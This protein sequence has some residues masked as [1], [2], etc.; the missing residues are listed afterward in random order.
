MVVKRL[1]DGRAAK[2][3]TGRKAVGSYAY[4]YIGAGKGKQRDAEPQS[5][6]QSAVAFIL[7]ARA[8]GHSYRQIAQALDV[9][10]HLPRR[11]ANWS[12][13]SVRSVAIRHSKAP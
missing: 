12:P 5:V 13:A 6:E 8:A 2:S 7:D 4:G 3:A 11:A 10:G 1:R 9:H